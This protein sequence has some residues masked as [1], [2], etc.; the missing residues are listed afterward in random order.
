M[1]EIPEEIRERLEAAE[2]V[3]LM[4]GWTASRRESDRDRALH[5]L[6]SRWH[7]EYGYEL[8]PLGSDEPAEGLGLT[9]GAVADLARQ[10]DE[11]MM[12]ERMRY[13][14][15]PDSTPDA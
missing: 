6:W 1:A 4:F 7:K 8:D 10:D 11:V 13:L 5:M 2:R 14:R 3:C 12:L 9:E 15:P